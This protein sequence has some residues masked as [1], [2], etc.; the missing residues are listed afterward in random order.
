M[1]ELMNEIKAYAQARGIKPATV[2]QNAAA[3]SGNTWDRWA[4]NGAACTVITAERIRKYM[5]EH[6]PQQQEGASP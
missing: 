2:L 3:L 5:S 1:E 4:R 6:P